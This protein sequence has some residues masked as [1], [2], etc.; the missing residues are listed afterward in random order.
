MLTVC[1][2]TMMKPVHRLRG[3]VVV[4]YN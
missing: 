4:L 1:K 3:E 2:H